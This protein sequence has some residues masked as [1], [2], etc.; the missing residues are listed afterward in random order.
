MKASEVIQYAK[1]GELKQLHIKSD[2]SVVIS[3]INL[4]IIELYKRFNLSIKVEV[5][6]TLPD[7]KVYTLRNTDINMVL[8]IYDS[9]GKKLE[10]K[11][12][13]ADDLYDITQLNLTTFLFKNPKDEEVLFLYK[14]SPPVIEAVSDNIEIPYDMLEALLNYI[15]YKGQTYMNKQNNVQVPSINFFDMFEKSCY[16]LTQLGYKMDFS[17]MEK[18]I[19]TKG[20]V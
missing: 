5:L 6:K 9:T 8:T 3:Y 12:L 19:R 10:Y 4:G 15:G 18:D 13:P 17:D 2:D 1:N 20:F 14:A 7:I 16:E 11:R